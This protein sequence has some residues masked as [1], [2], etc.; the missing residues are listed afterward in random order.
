MDKITEQNI[1]IDPS[2]QQLCD[3]IGRGERKIVIG[4]LQQAAKAFILSLLFRRTAQPL[5]VISPTEKEARAVHQDLAFFL[6]EEQLFFYP[7]WDVR[8]TD[9]F[10]FQADDSLRRME[11]LGHLSQKKTAVFVLPLQALMQ[12]VLPVRAWFDYVETIA[13]GD[14]RDR[15]QLVEKL[16]AGGYKR[17][18]LV[19]GKGEFGVR[20]S[21]L[22]IFPTTAENPLR[23]EFLGDELES[24]R[25]FSTASQRSA[26][27]LCDFTLF[28]AGEIILSAAGKQ[29]AVA[30][31]RRRANEL[32]LSALIK[33][34]L[35]EAVADGFSSS[36]NP[37]FLPLFYASA[38][39][40]GTDRQE[41]P[42]VLFDYLPPGACLVMDDYFALQQAELE[43]ENEMDRLLLKAGREE[44][45]Y[46]E[47]K[48]SYLIADD[49]WARFEDY[50]QIYIDGI[51][52]GG[53]GGVDGA[54]FQEV[55][56]IT[57]KNMLSRDA[58][59][60][61][62]AAEAGPLGFL[63]EHLKKHVLEGSLVVFLCLGAEEAQRMAHLLSQHDLTV[64]HDWAAASFW[65]A[66][67]QHH[68]QG[69]VIILDGKLSGGFHFPVWKLVVLTEEEL[70]GRKIARRR[71][72][73]LREGYFLQS[74]GELNDGDYAVHTEHGI[75]LYRGLQKL[76]IDGLENDF[77]L[78][79]YQGGDKLY[80]PVYRLD[81][82]QRYMGPS[83]YLPQLDKLGGNSW[84]AV[85][86]KIKKS[87]REMAEEL[88]AIYGARQ[89]L[90][91]HSFSLPGGLYDE[92]CTGFEFEETPDQAQAIEDMEAD[93]ADAKPMDRLIC[94][95]AG[96]GKTEVAIRAAFLVAME[97]KQVA[98]LVPTT[99][100]AEQHYQT[101][102]RRLKDWPIRVEVINRFKSK[103]EQQKIVAAIKEGTVDIVL[104]TH[105]L[106]QKDIDFKDLG[107]VVIDEEQQFGVAH[108]E[109]LKKL[110]TLVDVLTLT[111]TPIP[112]TLHLSMAG[113][114]DLTV[115]NT[116]P[117]DRL[118]IK[119]YLVEFD[120]E[121]IKEAIRAELARGGQVFF[122]H[123]RVRSIYTMAR[124]VEKLVPE[125]R[126]GVVHGRM[127]PK[128]IEEA[129]TRFVRGDN[130][131][132]VCTTIIGAGLDIPTANTIIINRADR[133]GL[134]QLYQIKGRVGRAKEEGRAYLLI[135]QG[136]MLSRD[137]RRRLQA[138]MDFSEHGS[139]F[140]ISYQDLE[141]R[142]GG[143]ILGASQSGQMSAVGYE[144]YTEL[145]EQTLREVKGQEIQKEERKP[146]IHL[147]VA[148]FIPEEYMA[149]MRQR[150]ITYKR[151]SLAETDAELAAIKE[152][153]VDCYGF[154]PDQ[155]RNL[156]EVLGIKNLLQKLRGKKMGYDR[157]N[158]IVSFHQESNVD[159][160]RILKLAREKWPAIRL[161]PDLQLYIPLPDL[162]ENE[163]LREAK[164]ILLLL[165]TGQ[166]TGEVG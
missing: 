106:L 165:S 140:R 65:T 13:L 161:T 99:I 48:S 30:N 127:K 61:H 21:V 35:V 142:G 25:I 105:R 71:T 112:R 14:I 19:E 11:I 97:G 39:Q 40:D 77:L 122:L 144:L 131:V 53:S 148:A 88:A 56:F 145:M 93:L 33:N 26:G 5:F 109:K 102:S 124:F 164:G 45:F 8:S 63:V 110:R 4:G 134:A 152:E 76:R 28:P 43:S 128:E 166:R 74:F 64:S 115:I 150:L 36:I 70:F 120:E 90:E 49:L 129:M 50:P 157:K 138:I 23:L 135:P 34:R 20:G 54:P 116:P 139:G 15:D 154:I 111:A 159:P 162:K 68:G 96:F 80:I 1:D 6:G 104:G 163:I 155:L 86:E 160:A 66:L 18:S 156:L 51:H 60:M 92:F 91:G 87:V 12:R 143:N 41:S 79:E 153:L 47:K 32:E 84:E 146:E 3:L 27:E 73:P 147:G 114:R 94:G 83:G 78:L 141:I 16:L 149:D 24:I 42:G 118:P 55:K 59:K 17:V 29:L 85:K 62:A 81:V 125:A 72:R 2:F 151:L 37:L 58:W 117:E 108:K 103:A 113:I 44:S 132:L 9:M 121:V 136:M 107:L 89:V 7:P 100:L 98:V 82:L 46:L 52:P 38:D 57:E 123:D 101:F 31:I 75:G 126:V 158:M 133:F 69:R 137:A 95:D 22:D 130:D 119:T 67:K 10:S